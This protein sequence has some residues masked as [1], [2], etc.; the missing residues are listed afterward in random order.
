MGLWQ[1]IRDVYKPRKTSRANSLVPRRRKNR[2]TFSP[3]RPTKIPGIF[4]AEPADAFGTWGLETAVGKLVTIHATYDDLVN[5]LGPPDPDSRHSGA[6]TSEWVLLH[7]GG[8]FTIYDYKAT[9]EYNEDQDLP[10]LD[11]FRKRPYDW[12]VGTDGSHEAAKGVSLIKR[13]MAQRR[14]ASKTSAR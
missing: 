10:S 9:S 1:L 7:N 8:R 3:G 11:E 4:R 2:S 5:L 6:I 14:R 12:H 13:A